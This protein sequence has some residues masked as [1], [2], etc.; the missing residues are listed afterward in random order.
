MPRQ[1]S[2]ESEGLSLEQSEL[3]DTAGPYQMPVKIPLRSLTEI[4]K[5]IYTS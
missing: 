5:H 4:N 3:V 1:T 2:A